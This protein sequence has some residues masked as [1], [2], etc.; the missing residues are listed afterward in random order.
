[1]LTTT[2][3]KKI[4]AEEIIVLLKKKENENWDLRLKKKIELA[5]PTIKCFQK[6][7]YLA[8]KSQHTLLSILSVKDWDPLNQ[9][10]FGVNF[11]FAYTVHAA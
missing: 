8:T 7:G 5:D 6:F 2:A 4:P 1:M 3:G 11:K 10:L 9:S